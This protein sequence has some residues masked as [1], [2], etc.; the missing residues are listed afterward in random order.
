MIIL[1][2]T[3]RFVNKK[4]NKSVLMAYISLLN[5]CLWC[6][7]CRIDGTKSLSHMH[8]EGGSK[9]NPAGMRAT[10]SLLQTENLISLFNPADFI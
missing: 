4:K 5:E 9:N 10:D 8:S 2:K 7:Y 3:T 1:S 6:S